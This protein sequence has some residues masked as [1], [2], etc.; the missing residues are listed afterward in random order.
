MNRTTTALIACLGAIANAYGQP[1]RSVDI[2]A[3]LAKEQNPQCALAGASIICY[4][5]G[6]IYQLSTA[7]S[8]ISARFLLSLPPGEAPSGQQHKADATLWDL[9]AEEDDSGNI[10]I[11]WQYRR[12]V[13][14]SINLLYVLPD[15]RVQHH[16]IK[17]FEPRHGFFDLRAYLVGPKFVQFFYTYY[18]E[19]YFSPISDTGSI[20]K[21]WTLGWRD[22]ETVFDAQVSE[23]GHVHTT[24]Y[25]AAY[26][27][28]G[29]FDMAWLEERIG[30]FLGP[31][32]KFKVGVVFRDQDVPRL[33]E[34]SE[35]P[36]EQLEKQDKL[37]TP[38][39][40]P[41]TGQGFSALASISN[42]NDGVVYK[43]LDSHG[44][45][46]GDYRVQGDVVT[47]FGYDSGTPPLFRYVKGRL[48]HFLQP[49]PSIK[50]ELHWTNFGDRDSVVQ[51]DVPFGSIFPKQKVA[52]C[53]YWLQPA[54]DGMGISKKCRSAD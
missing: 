48:T 47:E 11:A 14:D 24:R 26:R 3:I 39:M 53:F 33:K 27:G 7:A 1:A 8:P 17:T 45:V 22:G 42:S 16:T 46:I 49:P 18:S 19:K 23:R 6:T 29:K 35:T 51:L 32:R 40:A 34:A 41:S 4:A 37:I 15:G 13:I 20:Q 12:D 21:L 25:D 9:S 10:V 2:Q 5:A 54:R 38:V 44:K 30:A 36:I 28:E 52:N 31:R 43:K 50:A